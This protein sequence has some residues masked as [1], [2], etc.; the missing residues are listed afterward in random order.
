MHLKLLAGEH[1]HAAADGA[2]GA[3]AASSPEAAAAGSPVALGG[4]VTLLHS[5]DAAR[6][7]VPCMVPGWGVEQLA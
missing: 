4:R 6:R 1:A 5:L 3:L 2:R 7:Q